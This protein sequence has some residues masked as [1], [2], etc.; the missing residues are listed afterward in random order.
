MSRKR[1]PFL[2]GA[3]FDPQDRTL[4]VSAKLADV[5]IATSPKDGTVVIA[6]LNLDEGIEIVHENPR[7]WRGV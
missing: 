2:N 1:N 6:V 3:V 7:I 4:I 5:T